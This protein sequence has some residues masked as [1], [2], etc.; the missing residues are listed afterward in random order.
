MVI[1]TPFIDRAGAEWLIKLFRL[2][3]KP[4]EKIL[5]SRDYHVFKNALFNFSE[6]LYEM[7]VKIFDYFI[8]HEERMPPYETF[9]AKLVLGD[10]TQAYVGSA[11]ML[12]SSFEIALEVGTLIKGKSVLDIRR[13]VD[14]M[15]E[16]SKRIC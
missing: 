10:D 11:N 13:L 9:H 5:I 7:Q 15:I 16:A 12:A 8:R 2:T 14:S 3:S 4:V 1:V 6:K